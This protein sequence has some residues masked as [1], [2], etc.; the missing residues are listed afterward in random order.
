MIVVGG[1][2]RRLVVGVDGTDAA[3]A[4]LSW[5][6]DTVGPA[7]HI[8]AIVAVDPALEFVVDVVT[9]DT[10]T[11]LQAVYHDLASQWT[12]D[13]EDRVAELTADLVERT[14]PRA[15]AAAAAEFGA[16]AIVVGVHVT[17]L[18]APA[19]IGGTVRHLL[20][21]LEVPLVVVPGGASSGLRE[22]AERLGPLVVGVGHGHAT[23]AAVRWAAR[24]ADE[25]DLDVTLVR[26]TGDGPVFQ[27]DGLLDLISYELRPARRDQR[28]ERD[29][30]RL[31]KQVQ[32]L[33]EHDLTIDALAVPGLAAARL[34]EAS[35]V[36]SLLV[37]GQHRSKLT[38][39]RHT[40]QPLRHLLTHARC[41]IAVV[42]ETAV[43][44][45]DDDR[46]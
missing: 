14:A 38:L 41:P 42:P 27:T 4:A 25:R 21:E 3:Q 35:E 43:G 44:E 28:W 15:L 37:I 11:Y 46:G 24:L 5:A 6:A 2:M 17:H 39:G 30:V 29:L 40:A 34:A 19:R 36:A 13:V 1:V 10:M 9:G 16:D 8:H 45:P 26:A 22:H 33:S 23:D 32:D 7:G 12:S 31:A 18:G 20:R